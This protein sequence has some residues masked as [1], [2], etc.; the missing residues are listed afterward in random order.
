MSRDNSGYI[1]VRGPLQFRAGITLDGREHSKTW[2]TREAAEQWLA[3]LRR[4]QA[5][6]Y[7][8]DWLKHRQV[9]LAEA[10]QRYQAEITPAK[11]SAETERRRIKGLLAREPRLCTQ[12]LHEIRASDLKAFVKGRMA[13]TEP[14]SKGISGSAVNRELAILSHLFVIARAEWGMDDLANPVTK[15]L[16]RKENR[17]R[18]RRLQDG[19]EDQ[20]LAAARAYE[21]DCA[22]EI[23]I[24]AVLLFALSTAMR[25]GEIGRCR[26]EHVDLQ[27]A[28]VFL[29]DTKNGDPR[30]VPLYPRIVRMLSG[31][32]RRDDGLV[33][34]PAASIRQVWYRVLN[35]TSI[36]GLRLHDLRHEAISRFF[37]DTD[38][39]DM[40][41]AMISGHKTLIM[42]KRYA[43]LRA[44]KL[45]RKLARLEGGE[46]L[47]LVSARPDAG[48]DAELPESAQK[49]K[50]WRAI[51]ESKVLLAALMRARPV[52]ALAIEL[53]VSDVAIH[54]ACAR[55]GVEK[56]PR[57]Y[58]LR[59]EA[60]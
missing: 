11:K 2:S 7:A 17:A 14:G 8:G 60:A 49:R 59:S 38:L 40:E 58:W 27:Q 33:F 22:P 34:G 25:L 50:Q 57:G 48:E 16:R 5:G 19:E 1:R 42:L 39:S 9:T 20:L 3:S 13:P 47:T 46:T 21:R 24:T 45:A 26:W 6:G 30:T 37:E 53:S 55:L 31:L 23:P 29:P 51:S 43:H 44:N 15:G 32:E 56:P 28:T 41:I 54:K 12:P 10:L 4:A 18:N 35:R 52:S 36:D